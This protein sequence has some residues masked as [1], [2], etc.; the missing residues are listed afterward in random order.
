MKFDL[1]D[2]TTGFYTTGAAPTA[3]GV[4][5]T[6]AGLD[7]RSGHA[8]RASVAY[9]DGTL[10]LTLRDLE[11]GLSV[12]QSYAANV[13]ALVGGSSAY[14]GFTGATGSATATQEIL[15]WAYWG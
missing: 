6:A 5:L 4:A 10:W 7:L 15:N 8:F 11:T 2:N 9:A 3:G 1:S 14:V 13:S 12:T